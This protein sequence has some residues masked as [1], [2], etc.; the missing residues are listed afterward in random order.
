M[1]RASG[2]L[3]QLVSSVVEPMG[4]ELVGVEYNRTERGGLLRVY[5][6]QDEGIL[7][8]DCAKVSRQVSAILDVEDPIQENY[9]LE[10]SS[11]GMDRPLFSLQDFTRFQGREMQIKL[12]DKLEG[13]ANFKGVLQQVEGEILV[14]G[15]DNT[16]YDIPWDM[17]DQAHLVPKF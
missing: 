13:R 1:A 16:L 12:R 17:I 7:V 15:V 11:P 14:L 6:D 9:S 2:S 10:V 5:I 3:S 4:Y 8:D